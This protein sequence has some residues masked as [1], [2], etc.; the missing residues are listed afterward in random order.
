MSYRLL[1]KD[2]QVVH[3]PAHCVEVNF[4][5]PEYSTSASDTT[6][7]YD[8][9][10]ELGVPYVFVHTDGGGKLDV[11]FYGDDSEVLF[12][13]KDGTDEG[14]VKRIYYHADNTISQFWLRY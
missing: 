8:V 2:G 9:Y 12:P 13:F 7:Y 14:K 6:G 3:Q 4:T 5:Y 1:D 11:V 10:E